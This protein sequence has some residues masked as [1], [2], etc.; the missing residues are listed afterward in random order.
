MYQ[1]ETAVLH[2]CYNQDRWDIIALFCSQKSVLAAS[3]SFFFFLLQLLSCSI[4]TKTSTTGLSES[5]KINLPEVNVIRPKNK[6][7]LHVKHHIHPHYRQDQ[8]PSCTSTSP[9][10][11]ITMP[12]M[13]ALPLRPM[14]GCNGHVDGWSISIGV[15]GI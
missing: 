5:F 2:Y 1:R 10:R 14:I 13:L 6:G 4:K 8:Y 11:P 3:M 15:V 7:Y 9:P 12:C